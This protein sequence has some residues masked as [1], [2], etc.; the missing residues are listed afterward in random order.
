MSLSAL[1]LRT[2][3]AALFSIPLAIGVALSAGGDD[4][5]DLF[6]QLREEL[7]S[8]STYRTASGAPGH[9][10]WQQKVDY[11]IEVELD[12]EQQALRGS[13]RIRY[14]NTSP[15]PLTYLWLQVEPNFFAPQSHA[16]A[17]TL[18]PNLD[19]GMTFAA[20]RALLERTMI[21]AAVGRLRKH[22]DAEVSRLAA[23]IEQVWKEQLAEQTRQERTLRF[24]FELREHRD[25]G[26]A[27]EGHVALRARLQLP[28][29]VA[30]ATHVVHGRAP[31]A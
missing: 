8:P 15:D 25:V 26:A 19:A 24:L 27:M 1:P 6:A 23:R 3:L 10:Y 28:Q 18:A 14:Q 30:A 7:P 22:A 16:V 17:T 2:T 29:H 9:E 12:D 31:V 20:T 5:E 21:G 11:R 13:E 4:R